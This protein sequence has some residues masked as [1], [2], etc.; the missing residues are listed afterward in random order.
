MLERSWPCVGQTQGCKSLKP[1]KCL[2]ARRE[3]VCLGFTVSSEG[4]LPNQE[5]IKAI[6][7]YFQHTD[8]ESLRRLLGMIIFYRRQI[9][10]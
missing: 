2:L 10:R 8:S 4:V 9:Y 3:V 5:K 1:S 6:V 7:E